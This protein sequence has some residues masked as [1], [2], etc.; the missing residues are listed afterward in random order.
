[1]QTEEPYWLAEAYS[2][3]ISDLDLGPINCAITGARVVESTILLAYNPNARFIDWGGGYGVFTRLRR[4]R[5][6]DF[7]WR[8]AYCQSLFAKHFV[9]DASGGYKLMTSFEVFEHLVQPTEEIEA[10]LKLASNIIFMTQLPPSQLKAA[11]DWWYLALEHGQHIAIYSVPALQ[12]ISSKFSLHLTTDGS[13]LHLLSQKPMSERM[14]RVIASDGRASKVI[15]S[16]RRRK[17]RT[18]SLLLEDFRAVTGLNV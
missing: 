3:T 10:M 13:A 14:F 8:D 6:Y 15:R 12:F 1:M 18:Q 11:T 7:Y 9:A 5:G 4:D 17:L 2:S 16:I